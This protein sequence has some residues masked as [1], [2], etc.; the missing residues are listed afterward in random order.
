MD[1]SGN[2]TL[3]EFGGIPRL[4]ESSR[5]FRHRVDISGNLRLIDFSRFS[6]F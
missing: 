1:V 4:V 3:I 2:F 5:F 6:R